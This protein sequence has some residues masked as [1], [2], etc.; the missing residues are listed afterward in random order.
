[1]MKQEGYRGYLSWPVLRC[2]A[3][4]CVEDWR[5]TV[6]QTPESSKLVPGWVSDWGPLNECQPLYH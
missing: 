4:I 1:M 5:E 6:K 3:S 2:C